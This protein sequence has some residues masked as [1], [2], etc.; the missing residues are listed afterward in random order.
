MFSGQSRDLTTENMVTYR[1]TVGPGALDLMGDFSVQTS[2][3]ENVRAD[4]AVFATDDFN[5]YSLGSAAQFA[6]ISSGTSAAAMVSYLGRA[7]Y[8][9]GGKYIATLT[10]RYDGSSRFGANHKWAF[11]PS[12]GVAWRL[13]DEPFMRGQSL[14]NDL[15]LRLSYGQ[16][17]NQAVASY[18]SLW[19]LGVG[20]YSFGTTEVPALTPGNNKP[21]PDLKWEQQ[22]QL[23]AGVDA[24]FFDNRLSLSLDVYRAKTSDLLLSVSLPS[25]TGFTSQLQNVGSV[26]NRGVEVSLTSVNVQRDRFSWRSTLN[27]TAN[28][29][30]VLDLG[31][32]RELFL[33]PRTGNF[34]S[35]GDTYLLRV[36]EPLGSIYGY[37]VT[38]LWQTGDPCYLRN[39]ASTCVPGEYKIVD[40]NGDSTISSADRQILGHGD[41]DY[42][43]GLVNTVTY[44]PF[45]LDVLVNFTEG[46]RIINAGKA[47][48][49]M[50]L[51]QNNEHK[52]A[53]D[54]WTPTHTDTDI[55]RANQG[56]ARR[57]YSTLVEDGSYVRLQTLTLGF[58]LPAR[59]IPRATSAH[60]Y[61]TGQNLWVATRYSGFDPDV[62][63]MGG[64]ARFGGID[65]GAYPRSRV[66]NFGVSATF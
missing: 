29:S 19:L 28:R 10:G 63:S 2:Y 64:D 27:L 57:L 25:T 39:A 58:Q 9:V 65:I 56:R 23:N 35:P 62:N 42:Y 43:G 7:Q 8:N 18:Q 30:K 3:S 41:P 22:T 33:S 49:E 26:Q 4:G 37:R 17:G 50:L 45:S 13:S 53:L 24:A 60:V 15:K 21:N 46:N 32:A 14:V 51:L 38:G 54:R 11:F 20:F 5:A 61:V 36:G 6:G 1:R 12:A 34:F 31:V 16:V 47:Y 52:T 44:G 66:W 55:P 59:V 40:T 48:G